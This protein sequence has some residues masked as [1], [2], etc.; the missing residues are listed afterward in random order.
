MRDAQTLEFPQL[1]EPYRSFSSNDNEQSDA[2]RPISLGNVTVEAPDMADRERARMGR[3][4]CKF[5]TG[6]EES[7][8]ADSARAD[9]PGILTFFSWCSMPIEMFII[10]N[11][12]GIVECN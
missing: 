6:F 2:A 11:E 8:K 5:K 12:H 3:E 7:Q 9:S 4:F 1:F 10:W